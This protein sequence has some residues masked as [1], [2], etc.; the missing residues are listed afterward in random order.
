[1]ANQLNYGRIIIF[2]LA[3]LGLS[4]FIY[5]NVE[6]NIKNDQKVCSDCSGY[7]ELTFVC[8]VNTTDANCVRAGCYDNCVLYIT[9]EYGICAPYKCSPD[10]MILV[11]LIIMCF[12]AFGLVISIGAILMFCRKTFFCSE[13]A[14]P[15]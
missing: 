5:W 9:S 14:Q 13:I 2:V 15:F 3:W 4:G 6:S 11:S 10:S 1:M 12:Y 7:S 8:I